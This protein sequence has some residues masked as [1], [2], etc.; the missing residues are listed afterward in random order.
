MDPEWAYQSFCKEAGFE[1]NAKAEASGALG[2]ALGA[3]SQG[4][5][6]QTKTPVTMPSGVR[7]PFANPSIS[8]V[9]KG[10]SIL[11][12]VEPR[13]IG[14]SLVLL[15]LIGALGYGGWTVLQQVQR[16]TVTPVEQAPG[17]FAEVDPLAAPQVGGTD[18]PEFAGVVPST[19]DAL[20]R[21]YRPQALDAPVMVARDGPIGAIDPTATGALVPDPEAAR[22]AELASLQAERAKAPGSDSV[23]VM[24]VRPAWVQVRDVAGEI[25]FE[26]T[27]GNSGTY[28]VP[29]GEPAPILRAGAAG[30]VYFAVNGVVYGPAGPS[31]TVA[32]D[33]ALDE[34]SILSLFQV[35]DLSLDPAL[36]EVLE[37]QRA[38][39]VL[40]AEA[41]DAGLPLPQVT[42]DGPPEVQI[43][44][45]RDAWMRIRDG[46]GST[47]REMTLAAGQTYTV[48]LDAVGPQL[49][50]GDAGAVYFVKGG[51]AFGP[52]GPN[53]SVFK[54]LP[55][56]AE[57]MGEA[58]PQVDVAD[59][60]T[61][62]R[63]VWWPKASSQRLPRRRFLH[64]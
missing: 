62:V 2:S 28:I 10:D 21:L 15:A 6:S 40:V 39:G 36:E 8:F 12:N 52:A 57:A 11:A 63:D 34:A 13:A 51:Q 47:I 42:T 33:I 53:G 3:F 60:P 46:E 61:N 44:A 26:E 59:I 38:E 23:V 49:W 45:V 14:S 7:D 48:P 55:L 25:I 54:D 27:L 5:K 32:N 58:Y 41:R 50:I 64:T 20:D 9:P 4:S 56:T 29:A 16:V 17:V 19:P 18:A 37:R 43:V 24:A 1:L 35:A 31:G 22:E 30:G